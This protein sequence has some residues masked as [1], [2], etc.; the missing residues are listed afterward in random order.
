MADRQ[1]A[2]GGA[3]AAT[4]SAT[5]PDL[6]ANRLTF[7]LVAAPPGAKIDGGTGA[8]D[9]GAVPAGT[10]TLTVRVTDGGTPALSA[11]RAFKVVASAGGVEGETE[12][13]TAADLVRACSSRGIVLE[14]VVQAGGRV[15]LIGVADKRFAGQM[16]KLVFAAG[17]KVVARAKIGPD[18]SFST[19]APLPPR[20]LRGSNRARYEARVGNQRSLR[21]KLTR[22]V[23]GPL[24]L[25]TKDRTI[26]LERRV[27]CSKLEIVKRLQPRPN[28]AFSVAVDAPQGRTAAVYRLRT[29]VRASR[30]SPRLSSTFTLPRAVDFR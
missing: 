8:I 5:D 14:D 15:R 27:T 29:K 13:S 25:R 19:S 11:E 22:R 16:A 2:A 21:L 23:L 7:S 10:H 26:I 3:L 24:A 6:P 4:A 12:T 9:W 17:G 28:G 20:K 30:R 18:G 1:V